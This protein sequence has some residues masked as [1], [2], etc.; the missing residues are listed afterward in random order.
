MEKCIVDLLFAITQVKPNYFRTV[1]MRNDRTRY[2]QNIEQSFNA[3]L[4]H[5]FKNLMEFPINKEY[6]DRLTLNFDILKSSVES[7]PDIVLHESQSNRNDQRMFIE[8]KTNQ[9]AI[10]DNDFDKMITA[11]EVLDFKN[12]VLVVVNRRF[13]SILRTVRTYQKFQDLI[14]ENR[15]KI[16]II[17]VFHHRGITYYDLLPLDYLYLN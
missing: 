8:V 13:E 9:R 12:A 2:S 11:I 15:R 7:R 3:E 4:Y 6:Y 5:R 1:G 10:L 16:F 17:N 14:Q